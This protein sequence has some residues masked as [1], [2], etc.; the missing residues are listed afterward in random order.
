MKNAL[1][2]FSL[3]MISG[4]LLVGCGSSNSSNNNSSCS[5]NGVSGSM[6]NGTCVASNLSSQCSNSSYPYYLSSVSGPNGV[7]P[8]CCNTS[9]VSNQ[10]LCQSI[11][12]TNCS[13]YGPGWSW[14]GIQCVP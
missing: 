11:T 9:T 2:L 3:L 8:A 6:Q 1:K 7:G 14:N 4:L 10:T 12:N 5:T 13:Q